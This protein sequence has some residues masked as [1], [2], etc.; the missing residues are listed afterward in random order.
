[1]TDAPGTTNRLSNETSAYLRQHMHNPVDWY[2][3][4]EEAFARARSEDK[5]LLISIGYSAC[6]WCHVMAHESFEHDE[7]AAIMNELFVNVKVDREERP[8]VDQ[9]YMD[10]VVRLTG[11]GGWPLTVFCAPDGRPFYAGT[12]YPLEPRGQGPTFRQILAAVHEAWTKRRDEIEESAGQILEALSARPEGDASRPPGVANLLD[13]AN[14]LMQQADAKNGGFGGAPKFPT[15]T[16]LELL[17]AAS[18]YAPDEDAGT[19][20]GHCVL[21]GRE[22]ARRGLYDHLGGGFHRY[23]VDEVWAI[24]H[25]EKMLYDNGLLLRVYAELYRRT[26]DPEFAWPIRETI[27]Y[28]V[29]EMCGEEG[30]FYASQDADSEGEEGRFYVW[31]PLEVTAVLGDGAPA[32]L[33]AYGVDDAGNFEGGTTHLIDR[34]RAPRGEFAAER[35]TLRLHR[36][37]R[38]PPATDTKRV[39]AWNGYTIS[40]LARAA[41]QLDDPEVLERAAEAADFVLE[42]MRDGGGR[43][44]RV[45]AEGRAHVTGFLDDHAALLDACLDLHR[46]GAG[47][48]YLAAARALADEIAARF[49]DAGERDLFLTPSD[50][51]SLVHRPRSDNDGATPHAAGQALLGLVR[52]AEICGDDKL[53]EVV[54]SVLETHAFVL[55]RAPHAF[56]TLL[57]AGAL[58][59]HGISVAVIVGDLDDSDLADA[60]G[61][62]AVRA[63]KVLAPEDAVVIVPPGGAGSPD[64]ASTW[65]AGRDLQDGNPTAYV[66]RGTTC[67][68]PITR[69]EDF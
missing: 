30:A 67:S 49:Y 56:P 46:A 66:C 47:A 17:L 1:M 51:E 42:Q 5:P 14:Q 48:R 13:G 33:E 20:L 29:R 23:C 59:E 32:F 16:N 37:E 31:K 27:A 22:M 12:Y 55:E 53:R 36:S 11:H 4:G 45:F 25:F 28:L 68:L 63:R 21:S 62:L 15:P 2:P 26:R 39:A 8:D 18:L 61:A 38:I 6:H 43:L 34:A 54:R 10:T 64:I 52:V 35:E 41:S 19:F 7:S 65:L 60:T 24:P 69:A 9:I 3:W 44:L 57:R 40:G 58:A 50:G